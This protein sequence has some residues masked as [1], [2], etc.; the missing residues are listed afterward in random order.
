MSPLHQVGGFL[1]EL[2][3]G[4]P[5]GMARLLF[6]LLLASLLA[7]V[8]TLPKSQIEPEGR[9]PRLSENLKLWASVAL[10]IQILIYLL[11]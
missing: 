11:L 10:G 8:W 6:V 7:W 3:S 4:V 5:L 1:R 9:R 2:L